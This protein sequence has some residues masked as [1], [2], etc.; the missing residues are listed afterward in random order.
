[1]GPRNSVK[2][3][4]GAILWEVLFEL[5]LDLALVI[6]FVAKYKGKNTDF[7][8]PAPVSSEREAGPFLRA[9]EVAG[10]GASSFKREVDG[11]LIVP[12]VS[13]KKHI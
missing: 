12:F 9:V 10:N 6:E 13:H 8:I 5:L 4:V 2:S 7:R 3:G 11:S 1:M